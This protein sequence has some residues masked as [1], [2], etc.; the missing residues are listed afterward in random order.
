MGVV[1]FAVF[2][3]ERV[4]QPRDPDVEDARLVVFAHP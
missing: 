3:H 1:T 4:D 2:R